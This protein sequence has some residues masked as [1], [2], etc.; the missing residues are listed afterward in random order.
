[1]LLK[2]SIIR[3][4]NAQKFSKIMPPVPYFDPSMSL[5]SHILTALSGNLI[6]R[7]KFS[8]CSMRV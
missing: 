2:L 1:M 7:Q 6:H 5:E 8:D 3:L 4:S